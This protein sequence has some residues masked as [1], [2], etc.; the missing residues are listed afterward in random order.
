MF[1]TKKKPEEPL[2]TYKKTIFAINTEQLDLNRRISKL[3]TKFIEFEVIQSSM[4]EKVIRKLRVSDKEEK[5]P[6]E[7]NSLGTM[8]F[9]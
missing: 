3:E 9:I 2:E 7:L 8:K 6:E 1:W 5:K 4:L